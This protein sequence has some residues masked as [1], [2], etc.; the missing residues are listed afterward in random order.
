MKQCPVCKTT[1]TDETLKFCLSDGAALASV[2]DAEKT[3]AMSFG[4][5][6]VQMNIPP[7]SVPTVYPPVNLTQPAK[8]GISPVIAVI[9]GLLLLLVI[10][11]FA[12]FASYIWLKP[13]NNVTSITNNSVTPTPTTA[14]KSEVNN[15]ELKEK[16]ANLEKQI[17]DQKN[18]KAGNSTDTFSTPKTSEKTARVNSPGD[19]F[20]ALRSEPNSETG[21]RIAKIPHGAAVTVLGC[22]K[23][24]NIG[25]MSGHWCQVSYNGQS[26]WAF[27]A[28]MIF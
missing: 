8:K 11:C 25:K 26:G 1:Y 15:V 14:P 12:G 18:K 3:I 17:A 10:I 23:S 28:F 24:S 2:P 27:D 19:G 4:S 21:Y 16:L 9:L 5:R 13:T 22:P 6:P 7:D 20:L